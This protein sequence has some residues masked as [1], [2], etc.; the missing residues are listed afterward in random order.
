M[1]ANGDT[2]LLKPKKEEQE[3]ATDG[4]CN[5]QCPRWKED[6]SRAPPILPAAD[7][8]PQD[9]PPCL[10]TSQPL[11]YSYIMDS[12]LLQSTIKTQELTFSFGFVAHH[13]SVTSSCCFSPLPLAGSRC[14]RGR[15]RN[16]NREY[17][18]VS[19]I[20]GRWQV[21]GWG[22]KGQSELTATNAPVGR[23]V[24]WMGFVFSFGDGWGSSQSISFCC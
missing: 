7:L 10:P 1:S 19:G 11:K 2:K 18:L 12:S 13:R 21:E 24:H 5:L 4:A 9:P 22:V 20:L 3:E 6:Q 16:G 15:K 23:S 8:P 17:C 14:V